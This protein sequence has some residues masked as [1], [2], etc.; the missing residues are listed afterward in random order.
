M[1]T[2]KHDKNACLPSQR[3]KEGKVVFGMHHHRFY[4]NN[5]IDI[6]LVVPY[7]YFP[8]SYHTSFPQYLH[9]PLQGKRNIN[10]KT[11]AEATTVRERNAEFHNKI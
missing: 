2:G 4:D 9:F 1:Y 5:P 11:S 3:I 10:R 7:T 6:V 8:T